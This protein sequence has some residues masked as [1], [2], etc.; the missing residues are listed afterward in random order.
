MSVF[1]GDKVFTKYVLLSTLNIPHLEKFNSFDTLW[2]LCEM[3]AC[4]RDSVYG[5]DRL[6]VY[7]L[8]YILACKGYNLSWY[9]PRFLILL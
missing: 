9:I 7:K 1:N 5:F 8:V 6:T 2:E 4:A 3:G